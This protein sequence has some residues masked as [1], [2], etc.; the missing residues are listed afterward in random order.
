LRERLGRDAELRVD[1][2]R[3]IGH[4][5]VHGDGSTEVLGAVALHRWTDH[6]CDA[7]IASDGTKR[8]A[9]RL[10][11][12]TVY[13]WAFRHADKSRVNFIVRPSNADSVLL[14]E[15]LGHVLEARL[16]DAFGDGQ[17]ALLY[18]LTRRAW[19]QSK[20]SSPGALT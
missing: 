16:A 3:T 2:C 5:L 13:D 4:V 9:S 17:D 1:E 6:T 20:W 11:I 12:F 8:W 7:T 14:Q 15:R 10:F 18:G 19:R